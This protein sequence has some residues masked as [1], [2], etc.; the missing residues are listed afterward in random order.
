MELLPSILFL[1]PGKMPMI[2]A[3]T[4]RSRSAPATRANRRPSRGTGAP[5]S[6]SDNG[7]II[8]KS[9][10]NYNT[11]VFYLDPPTA[12]TVLLFDSP[13]RWTI[14]EQLESYSKSMDIQDEYGEN[15]F[16]V[17]NSSSSYGRPWHSS[18]IDAR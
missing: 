10:Y 1:L 4:S 2:Y 12:P 17:H 11:P 18:F 16:R 13:T 6:Y 14:K 15:A 7:P 8:D 5:L 3:R 9:D